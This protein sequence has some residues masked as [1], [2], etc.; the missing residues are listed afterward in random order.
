MLRKI[1]PDLGEPVEVHYSNWGLDP[2]ARGS[3]HFPKV[4]S[5]LG[6]DNDI[7]ARA[8]GLVHFAG[9]HTSRSYATVHGAYGS[10]ERAANEVMT[11][12]GGFK[13]HMDCVPVGTDH[14]SDV[15]EKV[16]NGTLCVSYKDE[17]SSYG[18]ED[19]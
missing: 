12:I 5:G 7:M 9:E 18:E 17:Y 10:G 3:Y 14:Y 8:Q 15:I 13:C 6:G 2:F 19:F 16:T 4:G 11:V 1:Y